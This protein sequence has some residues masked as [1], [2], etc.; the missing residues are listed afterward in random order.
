MKYIIV[1]S[2][3]ILNLFLLS[4]F[5]MA[6]EERFILKNPKIK[7]NQ[8]ALDVR[9][10]LI[11]S[12]S[13]ARRVGDTSLSFGGGLGF[14]WELNRHTFERNIWEASHIEIF[15]RFQPFQGLQLD[16][17]P[18]LMGYIWTDDCSECTGTFVGFY[19][20]AVIGHKFIFG[21]PWFR[22]GFADDSRHGSEFGAIL[23]L[24]ARLVL[25]WGK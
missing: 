20:S 17:G 9:G 16:F 24:Q 11:H 15:A 23:G 12:L 5:S 14:G 7:K 3:L 22:I 10:R 2:A 18:T 21:G 25:S 13:Y 6:Q 4:G 19:F 1:L 8:V